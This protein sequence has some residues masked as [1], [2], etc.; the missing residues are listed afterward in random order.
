M[1]PSKEDSHPISLIGSP[2][3]LVFEYK[4]K[5]NSSPTVKSAAETSYSPHFPF[6]AFISIPFSNA[7]SDDIVFEMSFAPTFSQFPGSNDNLSTGEHAAE[8]VITL[9]VADSSPNFA[10]SKL[11]VVVDLPRK[12]KGAA[13][14]EAYPLILTVILSEEEEEGE[15]EEVVVVTAN[16]ANNTKTHESKM[17]FALREKIFP[18]MVLLSSFFFT[19]KGVVSI[20]LCCLLLYCA[21]SRSR[22]S[23]NDTYEERNDGK[24]VF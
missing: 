16:V 6:T 23:Q 20:I 17:Y 7:K 5:P 9:G 21:D 13:A 4:K 19:N 15:E 22:I 12:N 18:L 2:F 14:R 24:D 3:P 11:D 8:S 1:L 10:A